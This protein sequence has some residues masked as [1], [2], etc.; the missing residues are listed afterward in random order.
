MSESEDRGENT[1]KLNIKWQIP[2]NNELQGC[3][4][5]TFEDHEHGRLLFSVEDFRCYEEP[6]NQISGRTFP[7]QW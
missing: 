2:Q 5:V 7:A 3:L 6:Q 4:N 1:A